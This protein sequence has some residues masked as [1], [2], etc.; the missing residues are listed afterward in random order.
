LCTDGRSLADLNAFDL[1]QPHVRIAGSDATFPVR[2]I[3]CI[4]QNYAAHA[5][6]MGGDPDREPPFYFM[7]PPDAVIASGS[8]VNWPP[9]T[10]NLHHEIELVVAI[11]RAGANIGAEEAHAH[12]FGYA[13][14]IDLTRRDLQAAAKKSGR[15]WDTAKGFDQSAPISP[16]HLSSDIGHPAAGRIWLEVNG[17]IRQDG[18]IGQMIWRVPEAIAELSTLF[19]L[20]PGDLLFTGTPEGVGPLQPGDRV[21]GGIDGVDEIQ[22]ELGF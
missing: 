6:E 10:S 8:T 16:I 2:R 22:V 19:M 13:A 3:Y 15:P 7:K 1:P 4:G 11:G 20:Q 18:D 12:I 17:E 9:R 14:G 21:A 5:R